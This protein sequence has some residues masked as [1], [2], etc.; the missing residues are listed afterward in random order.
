MFDSRST[1]IN[2]EVHSS[3]LR[4]F[5]Y[6]FAL[7]VEGMKVVDITDV[8]RPLVKAALPLEGARDIYLARTYAYIAAG[9]RG[10]AIVDIERP[11][12]PAAPKFSTLVKDAW[13]VRIGMTKLLVPRLLTAAGSRQRSRLVPE[14]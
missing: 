12:H 4:R 10:L 14:A 7:D 5:R 8:R 9:Q 13:A 3:S 11:E 2:N 1:A 6:L